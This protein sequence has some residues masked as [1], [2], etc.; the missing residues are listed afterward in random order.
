MPRNDDLTRLFNAV[1]LGNMPRA[2]ALAIEIADREERTGKPGAAEALRKALVTRNGARD[3]DDIAAPLARATGPEVLTEIP[4]AH[5]KDVKLTPAA[6]STLSEI[7]RE[8]E[9]RAILRQHHLEPRNRIFFFGPPGC[10]KTL[11]ARA[12]AGELH[13]PLYVVRY[14]SLLGAYLGQ[15]S[16]RLHEVFR[17][18]AANECVLLIDEIDAVGRKRGHVGDIAEVDR[19][20]ISLMQQLDLVRPAGLMIAASNVPNDIDPALLRRFDLALEFPAPSRRSLL[21]FAQK[22]A[23]RRGLKLI[24]GVQHALRSAAT[25]ADAEQIVSDELRRMLVRAG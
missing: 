15:T 25:Y 14:D 16:F 17:F 19:V 7:V 3:L 18:A 10:G 11:T 2:R 12:I 9:H 23:T 22:M 24:N 4:T 8:F 21:D 6:R 5:I 20:V 1:A 13:V